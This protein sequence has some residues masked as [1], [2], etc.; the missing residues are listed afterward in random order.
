M[1]KQSRRH[2]NGAY[3]EPPALSIS[4]PFTLDNL[5]AL[6]AEGAHPDA[7]YTHQQIKDWA[8]HFW[9]RHNLWSAEPRADIPAEIVAAANLAQEIEMQWDMYLANTYTLPELQHLD[10]S[11]VQLPH[12]WFADWLARLDQLV[13]PTVSE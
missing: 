2:L 10:V 3:S 12:E 1:S 5:R 11:R 8:E 9:Q 7:H 6:L 4:L 13:G